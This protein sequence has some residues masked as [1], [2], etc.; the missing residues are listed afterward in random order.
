[1]T[2]YTSY[3]TKVYDDRES[4]IYQRRRIIVGF[5]IL[6]IILIYKEMY[7]IIQ[8]WGLNYFV[9]HAWDD[10]TDT[11]LLLLYLLTRAC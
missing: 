1:M 6:C 2:N 8:G 10:M 9:R 11:P 4:L 3:L 7:Y 5:T